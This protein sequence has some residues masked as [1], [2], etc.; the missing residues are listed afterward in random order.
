MKTN[1]TDIPFGTLL[2]YQR[3]YIYRTSSITST[4]IK[5]AVLLFFDIRASICGSL[6]SYGL[7]KYSD[8]RKEKD[9]YYEIWGDE[10]H[11]SSEM[12]VYSV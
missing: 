3:P 1:N 8:V 5:M 4:C 9:L 10:M 2:S 12:E 6:K 11:M 7:T